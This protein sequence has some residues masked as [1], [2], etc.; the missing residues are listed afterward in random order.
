MER[1]EGGNPGPVFRALTGRLPTPPS[2]QLAHGAPNRLDLERFFT[3]LHQELRVLLVRAHLWLILGASGNRFIDPTDVPYRP[4]APVVG[5]RPGFSTDSRS[6]VAPIPRI[7]GH[8]G[9]GSG[10]TSRAKGDK[11]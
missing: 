1:A 8:L 4:A 11:G 3:A 5:I 6:S 9:L 10:R 2:S 7:V